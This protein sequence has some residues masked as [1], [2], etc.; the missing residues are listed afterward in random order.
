MSESNCTSRGRTL[1]L[2]ATAFLM[3]TTTAMASEAG[4]TGDGGG[5]F[6]WFPFLAPFHSVVLHL[7]IGFVL[8]ACVLEL[9]NM[10]RASEEGRRIM[11]LVHIFTVLA[12]IATIVLGL[13]RGVGG[14]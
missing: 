6:Q 11:T 5:P 4:A 13:M 7:P 2:L 3:F 8:L 14:G 10:R 9:Y 1:A 12:M